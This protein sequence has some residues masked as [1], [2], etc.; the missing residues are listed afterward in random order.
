VPSVRG[1]RSAVIGWPA[2]AGSPA[3]ADVRVLAGNR[4]M[5]MLCCWCGKDG[6]DGWQT[7]GMYVHTCSTLIHTCVH[8]G[9]TA[10][11]VACQAA[12][13]TAGLQ[14][15]RLRAALNAACEGSGARGADR[16]CS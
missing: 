12:A 15:F 16:H 11:L 1:M 4:G 13:M 7:H 8:A 14:H 3:S 2:H 6:H 9:D 10:R 5:G